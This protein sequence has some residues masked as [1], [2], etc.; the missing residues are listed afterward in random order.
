MFIVFVFVVVFAFSF[1]VRV[2]AEGITLTRSHT[3]QHSYYRFTFDVY[4]VGA[5]SRHDWPLR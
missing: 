1:R 4:V 2:R 5:V 3:L